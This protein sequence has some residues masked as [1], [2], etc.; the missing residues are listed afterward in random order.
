MIDVILWYIFFSIAHLF[1]CQIKYQH[2][3]SVSMSNRN[4]P[5][6]SNILPASVQS[7]VGWI[8]PES[9]WET[10][11][12][13][14]KQSA[15]QCRSV[16]LICVV[17]F[18]TTVQYIYFALNFVYSYTKKNDFMVDIFLCYGTDSGEF[19]LNCVL[20]IDIAF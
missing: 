15:E 4:D 10:D 18:G 2:R 13:V 8:W 16:N 6:C 7:G 12:R 19:G 9:T 1:R 11:A 17:L 20:F 14:Y 3:A 5:F